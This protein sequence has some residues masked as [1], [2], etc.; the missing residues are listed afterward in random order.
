MWRWNIWRLVKLK[1][2]ILTCIC[3]GLLGVS[4][5]FANLRN[6]HGF[7][8]ENTLS[9]VMRPFGWELML[10]VVNII[11]LWRALISSPKQIHERFPYHSYHSLCEHPCLSIGSN[12]IH[13]LLGYSLALECLVLVLTPWGY[14]G[15]PSFY[16]NSES[17]SLS[18]GCLR[19]ALTPWGYF[20]SPPFYLDSESFLCQA[21]NDWCLS[22]MRYL[23][24]GFMRPK[25]WGETSQVHNS[26]PSLGAWPLIPCS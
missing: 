24:H 17:F 20:G 1:N 9:I 19:I 4:P 18:L 23:M 7:I 11:S 16:L 21:V 12:Y 25:G 6:E 3:W 22:M 26:L 10:K 13:F 14:S 2:T 8:S 5:T 15:S